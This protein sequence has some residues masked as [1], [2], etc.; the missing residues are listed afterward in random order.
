[1]YSLEPVTDRFTE[2]YKT[3]YLGT[4]ND[5]LLSIEVVPIKFLLIVDKAVFL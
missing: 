4:Y 3:Y 1:M 2:F 5:N